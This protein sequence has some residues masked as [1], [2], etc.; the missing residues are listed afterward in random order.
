MA[1]NVIAYYGIENYDLIIYLS[2]ILSNLN[3]KV[4]V[5]DHSEA[6]GLFYTIPLPKGIDVVKEP[7][8]F[9]HVDFSVMPL[10]DKILEQYDD[11]LVSYGFNM[12]ENMVFSKA[13]YV[14]DLYLHNI[15]RVNKILTDICMNSLLVRNIVDVKYD[16]DMIM[17]HTGFKIDK[18]EIDF[19]AHDENDV[20]NAIMCQH[21]K[22]FRF[23][24]IS[25]D[26]KKYLIK[27]VRKLYP[28]IDNKR[29][30]AAYLEAR[31]GK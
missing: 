5:L 10:T 3:K 13:V 12:P 1:N 6:R 22:S 27:E 16:T 25:G 14:T 8:T 20:A 9:R 2:K 11:V 21:N 29:I 15:V 23:M 17:E 7:I 19:I 31:K 30:N 26:V 4:I 28:N 24:N 18:S